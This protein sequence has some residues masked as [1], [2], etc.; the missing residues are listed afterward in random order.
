MQTAINYLSALRRIHI[1]LGETE[2]ADVAKRKI[3]IWRTKMEADSKKKK[4]EK[5]NR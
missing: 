1:M 2:E 4:M 3:E 5:R